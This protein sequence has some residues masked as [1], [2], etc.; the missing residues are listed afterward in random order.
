VNKDNTDSTDESIVTLVQKGDHEAF[1]LLVD[2]YQHK[3][4]RY[5]RKFLSRKEDIEDMVQNIFI[6]AYE[7][8][9]SFNTILKFS[10]WI[11]RIAHNTF[12]NALRKNKTN[13]ISIDFDTLLSHPIYED[14]DIKEREQKEMRALIDQ[15]LDDIGSKY[16][17]VL[18]LHYLEDMSYKDIAEILQVPIGTIGIRIKRAK[19]AIKEKI[20]QK[21]L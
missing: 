2:R 20:D 1:G 9:Q 4:T 21:K 16:R 13:F 8:I 5:G 18:V 15:G 19:E 3:L 7:N 11:Y 6:S 14:P 12:V 17:E 10:S